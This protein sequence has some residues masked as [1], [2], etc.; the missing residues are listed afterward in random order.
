M[1]GIVATLI[2][3]ATPILCGGVAYGER[4]RFVELTFTGQVAPRIDVSQRPAKVFLPDAL[5]Q[6]IQINLPNYRLPSDADYELDWEEFYEGHKVPF[7]A[8]GDFNNDGR[9][10]VAALL[11]STDKSDIWRLV[12]FHGQKNGFSPTVLA[13]SPEEDKTDPQYGRNYGPVQHV[14]IE[15]KARCKDGRACLTLFVFESASHD[16]VWDGRKYRRIT[17]AD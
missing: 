10:D 1:R 9:K 5:R 17:T 11:I 13:T 14:G 6:A 2:V 12:V 16:F 15:R 4:A 7:L 3:L 8:L